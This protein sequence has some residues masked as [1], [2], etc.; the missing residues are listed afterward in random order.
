MIFQLAT[1][2]E[3]DIGIVNKITSSGLELHKGRFITYEVFLASYWPHFSQNLTKA[4]GICF[5]LF[6]DDL[7]IGVQIRHLSIVNFWV[8]A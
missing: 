5:H 8:F 4:L 2:L 7:L 6:L 3:A 1:L